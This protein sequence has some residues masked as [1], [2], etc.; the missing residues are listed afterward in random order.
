MRIFSPTNP[1]NNVALDCMYR[2]SE[3]KAQKVLKAAIFFKM[4]TSITAEAALKCALQTCNV[5]END[6]FSEHIL[7]IKN[8]LF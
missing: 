8:L 1:F 6:L 7:Y 2:D 3:E 4:N 5:N